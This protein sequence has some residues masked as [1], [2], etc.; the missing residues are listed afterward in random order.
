[1]FKHCYFCSLNQG[2]RKWSSRTSFNRMVYLFVMCTNLSRTRTI[3]ST[4]TT[5]FP[6]RHGELREVSFWNQRV[7]RDFEGIWP[8]Q[9]KFDHRQGGEGRG[10]DLRGDVKPKSHL[11]YMA[12]CA[13]TLHL[14][15]IKHIL[16]YWLDKHVSPR[17]LN[18]RLRPN[19]RVWRSS[20]LSFLERPSRW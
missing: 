7:W 16:S 11:M 5:W 2:T 15:V 3:V 20:M 9:G 6:R 10:I 17:M 8:I 14:F 19:I 12:W 18:G 1:M 4:P 13:L